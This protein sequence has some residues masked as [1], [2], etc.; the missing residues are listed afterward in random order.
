MPLTVS[1]GRWQSITM[2]FLSGIR[3]SVRGYDWTLVVIDRLT[4]MAHFIPTVKNLNTMLYGFAT[5]TKDII[6]DRDIIRENDQ[7]KGLMTSWG[8]T[9]RFSTTEHPQTDGQSERL[10]RAMQDIVRPFLEQLCKDYTYWDYLLHMAE[11]AYNNAYQ[12]SID[13]SP[14]YSNYGYHPKIDYFLPKADQYKNG[15]QK[16]GREFVED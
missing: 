3:T 13:S 6:S 7:W 10:N 5:G 15:A 2:D 12:A 4:K 16:E 9:T 11:F 1:D 8:I 14:F